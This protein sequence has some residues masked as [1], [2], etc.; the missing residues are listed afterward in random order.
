[1]HVE[2]FFINSTVRGPLIPPY[3]YLK[4]NWWDVYLDRFNESPDVALVGTMVSCYPNPH[5]QSYTLAMD[6]RALQIAMNTWNCPHPSIRK[7]P[8]RRTQWIHS[9]EVAFST[10][11]VKA[12]HT[13]L[14][15]ASLFYDWDG[16]Q[17]STK[18]CKQRNPTMPGAYAG[19]FPT[20][21]DAVFIKTGGDISRLKGGVHQ[22]ILLATKTASEA[23]LRLSEKRRQLNQAKQA[24][25]G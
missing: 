19:W 4:I 13:F 7:I 5:V 2:I 23:C 11:V 25:S 12:G 20:P 6:Q 22:S 1:M 3:L 16:K 18:N 21:Y 10:N 14:A 8:K 17:L 15:T 9:T 24:L